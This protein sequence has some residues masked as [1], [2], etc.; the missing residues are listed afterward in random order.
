MN[1]TPKNKRI[2]IVAAS[3]LILIAAGATW[4]AT[5]T[6]I[7]PEGKAAAIAVREFSAKAEHQSFAEFKRGLPDLAAK[8]EPYLSSAFAK[9]EP[10]LSNWIDGAWQSWQGA[11]QSSSIMNFSIN[12][13]ISDQTDNYRML[14]LDYKV[15]GSKYADGAYRIIDESIQDN[16]SLNLLNN[17]RADLDKK[18]SELKDI[19]SDHMEIRYNYRD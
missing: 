13:G 1:I 15:L 3:A 19:I 8:V 17:K 14:N 5:R 12:E 10:Y 16:D 2:A 4:R 9:K 18:M 11:M 6:T 7:S